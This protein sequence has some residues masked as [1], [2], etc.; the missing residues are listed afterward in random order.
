MFKTNNRTRGFEKENPIKILGLQPF[1]RPGAQYALAYKV[2]RAED[3]EDKCRKVIFKQNPEANLK[4]SKVF[5]HLSVNKPFYGINYVSLRYFNAAGAHESGT[6]GE[7]HHPE[8]HFDSTDSSSS[9]WETRQQI[10]GANKSVY[11]Y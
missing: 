2:D 11:T 9:A 3:L 5:T 1:I 8:T 6:I 10:R 7:D 4:I